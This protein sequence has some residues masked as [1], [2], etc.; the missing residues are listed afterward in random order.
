[1][2]TPRFAFV[3]FAF[4]IILAASPVFGED[5]VVSTVYCGTISFTTS[6]LICKTGCVWS[7]IV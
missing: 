7:R 2:K 6:G 3:A 5:N 1:M 4:G